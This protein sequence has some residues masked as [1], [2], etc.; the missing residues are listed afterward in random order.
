MFNDLW[1]HISNWQCPSSTR[2]SLISPK[3]LVKPLVLEANP[4]TNPSVIR[5]HKLRF[6]NCSLKSPN[7]NHQHKS[8]RSS[9]SSSVSKNSQ[10]NTYYQL[11]NPMS[12]EPVPEIT[13][14]TLPIRNLPRTPHSQ[15]SSVKIAVTTKKLVVLGRE[16]TGMGIAGMIV[17]VM[18]DHF[19][20]YPSIP[21]GKHQ[22]GKKKLIPA[23]Q[24]L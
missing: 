22:W 7:K 15:Q 11:Q 10:F 19:H 6:L 13:V 1:V 17:I 23:F 12:S 24:L 5:K 18:F 14:D 8:T 21:N 16:W 3:M 2:D 9:R 4:D 20:P